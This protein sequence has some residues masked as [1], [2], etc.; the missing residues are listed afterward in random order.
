M[1][2]YIVNRFQDLK[3]L[4]LYLY[5]PEYQVCKPIGFDT[6]EDVMSMNFNKFIEYIDLGLIDLD[7]NSYLNPEIIQL[8]N[9]WINRDNRVDPFAEYTEFVNS[10]NDSL[11]HAKF[12]FSKEWKENNPNNYTKIQELLKTARELE[13]KYFFEDKEMLHRVIDVLIKI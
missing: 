10:F 6:F 8:E 12:S 2:N 9:F 1:K 7:F 11:L 5:S 13:S 3:F 4:F